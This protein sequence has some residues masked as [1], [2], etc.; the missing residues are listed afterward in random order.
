MVVKELTQ[1]ASPL[2]DRR[3]SWQTLLDGLS[4]CLSRMRPGVFQRQVVNGTERTTFPML[5][6]DDPRFVP[7]RLDAQ[8][9]TPNEDVPHFVGFWLGLGLGD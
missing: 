4:H 5:L 2:L 9:Q 6:G 7:T 8:D 3:Q 1:G